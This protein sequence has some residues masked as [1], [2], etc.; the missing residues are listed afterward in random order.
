[1]EKPTNDAPSQ[2]QGMA[3]G[4]IV[5]VEKYYDTKLD[6]VTYAER[7]ALEMAKTV[8]ALGYDAEVITNDSATNTTL[9]Y[10]VRQI[11]KSAGKDDTILFFFSGHGYLFDG[12]SYLLAYDSR[13]GDVENTATPIAKI[14]ELFAQSECRRIMFF[15]DC[16][17]SG[18][19]FVDE[20]RGVLDLMSQDELKAYF[21]KAEYRVVFSSCDRNEYSYPSNKAQHGYWTYSLLQALKGEKPELLDPEGRLRSVALQDYLRHEVP[22][23]VSLQSLDPR[24]QNPKMY[25]DVSGTFVVADLSAVIAKIKVDR[26]VQTLGLKRTTLRGIAF[27]PVN[28]LSGFDRK[29]KHTVPD[30]YSDRSRS[31]VPSLAK[32][33]LTEEIDQFFEGVRQTELYENESLEYDA[34]SDGSAAIR[35]PDFHFYISYAQSET[36]PGEFTVTRELLR[37]QNPSLLNED[38]FNELFDGTFDEAVFQFK[39]KLDV[40]GFIN[41]AEKVEGMQIQYNGKRTECRI[42]TDSFDGEIIASAESIIYK[43]RNATTPQEMI[44]ELRNAHSD[45]LSVP[46]LQNALP[47]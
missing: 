10:M 19:N 29:R 38:W 33:E 14:L 15:L 6:P 4:L 45:L 34:P 40:N 20:A 41:K 21:E 43:F 12:K 8:K 17:H 28:D 25:G 47:L 46:E 35:T 18:M 3:Y 26:Q 36:D 44:E 7:D 5:A 37:I 16:C 9:Q 1:M 31:W 2:S 11:A 22:K 39:G 30:Y 24:S 13:Q 27:G 23:Q 32:E 42:L